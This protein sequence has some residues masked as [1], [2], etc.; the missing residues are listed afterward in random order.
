MVEP[1]HPR[2]RPRRQAG[3]RV[4]VIFNGLVRGR[5][6]RRLEAVLARL[7]GLGCTVE[8]R[9]TRG[10][11]EVEGM[12]RH[13]AASGHDVVVAA[14]G[15]GTV[16]EVVNGL[17]GSATPLAVLPL[18][19]ANAREFAEKSHS[20]NKENSINLILLATLDIFARNHES[21]IAYAERAL[22]LST[23]GGDENTLTGWVKISSGQPAE[24]VEL[25]KLGMRY[26]PDYPHYIPYGLA[27]GLMMLGR[28]DEAKVLDNG[29]LASST[30]DVRAHPR[31]TRQLAAMAMFEGDPA[32]ARRFVERLLAIQSGASVA[33]LKRD[34]Y[35]V[36]DQAFVERYADA[37]RQAGLPE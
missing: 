8:R 23:A 11:G 9:E 24:G 30:N 5:R 6:R 4:L 15:D 35:Y 18:G 7:E 34:H 12:A 32:S 2:S 22:E 17:A 31:A 28:Y 19:T 16:N 37:L 36:K 25:M 21:A 10:A 29:L 1:K 13:G 20:I 27:F 14:G 33:S 3:R 26:E